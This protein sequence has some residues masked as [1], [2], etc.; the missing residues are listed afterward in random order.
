MVRTGAYAYAIY[1]Y[2]STT[3]GGSATPNKSFGLK[4]AVTGLTL[5]TN[6]INLGKLGQVE[7]T[8]FAYGTQGGTLG[9]GFVLATNTSHNIFQA[10]FGTTTGGDG[11][12][13]TAAVYGGDGSQGQAKSKTFIDKSFTTEIGFQ[14]ETD[15][16]VRTLK[17]CL[18]NSLSLSA[19]IGNP[20]DCSAD[21]V[22]GK[23]DAPSNTGSDFDTGTGAYETSEP[24]TFAHGQLKF[25][26]GVLAEV[27]DC[28]ITFTQNGELLYA[29]GSQQSVHAI[30]K[31]LDITGRFRA[32]WRNDDAIDQLI[33]QLKSANYA[34]TVGGSPEL[35]LFFDNGKTGTSNRSIKITGYGLSIT[36][37]SVTGLEPVEPIFEEINWQI[38]SCKVEAINA[39]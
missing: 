24:F 34:Q 17:G 36:D 16:M 30:K 12:T 20:V 37:H 27:Q 28:D 33:L 2:E 38:K 31:M 29:L 32:S 1:G 25:K 18:L 35:E 23:E 4:T 39:A 13:G 8:S 15:T 11:T 21:I 26:G 9:I 7:P 22:Y 10:I 3:I 6:R 19:T 5:T 14:G